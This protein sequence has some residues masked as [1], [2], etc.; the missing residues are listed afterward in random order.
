MKKITCLFTLLIFTV[1]CVGT[2]MYSK[3]PTKKTASQ[4]IVQS[5]KHPDTLF[6]VNEKVPLSIPDVKERIDRE[7]LVNTYWQS[8]GLLLIKRSQKFFPII[9]PILKAHGIP[10]D[11]KY[12]AVIES[13]LQNI[14]SPAGAKGFWQLMPATAK[15]F[16]LE[17][18]KNIDER[19]HLEKATTAACKYIMD[20]KEKFGTWTDAAAS[21]N[22]GMYGLDKKLKEQRV[23]S[24]YD[25][26]LSDET[27][28]YV[29]RIIAVKEILSAPQDY[30]FAFDAEDLYHY[31]KYQ[32]FEIDSTIVSLAKF[33]KEM[34]VNYKE[35][36][37][38]NPW[39]REKSLQNKSGKTY[40]VKIMQH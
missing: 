15:D 39:M 2:F 10:D 14:T 28:R 32:V 38:L 8:N 26:L 23:N 3:K 17:V 12:L 31:P 37:I 22:M 13:G 19:Y 35:L 11:F 20:A 34:G 21:Y 9:E 5:V 40:A 33:S 29:P 1:F 25:L 27:M 30:G 24:Y 7:F 36:K 6:F 4:Y 18:N 16:G